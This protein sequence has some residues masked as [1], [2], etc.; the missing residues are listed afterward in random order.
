[1][2]EQVDPSDAVDAA[3]DAQLVDAASYAR[4]GYPHEL[5]TR[6]RADAPVARIEPD[7]YEPFWA[8]TKHADVLDIAKQPL[9][10]S[11]AQGITLRR[12]GTWIPPSELVVMLDPPRH[13]PVR[14]VANP[15]FTP[16]AVT[17]RRTEIERIAVE[18]LDAAAP[19]GSSGDFDFVERIAAPFPLAVIASVLGVPHHDWPRLL[20]WTNEVIGKEDPEYRQPG[21]TPGQTAKRARGEVHAYFK[22]L[23]EQRR[24]EPQA[25]LMTELT[26]GEIDGAPLTDEQL[27]LYCELLVEAG[28]ET[29]RNAITGGLLAFCEH[30]G[31][32]EKL[33]DRPKLLADAVEEILRWVTPISHFTRTATEDS[34]IRG[35]EIQAGEQVALYFASANR[36]EDVFDDPFAFRVDRSPNPHLAFGFGAH[37]C[38]GAQI[39][40]V[41]LE[42]IF[43]LLLA[44]LDS[45]EVSGPVDRLASIVNGSI[46]HLPLRYNMR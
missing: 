43:R 17:A 10:F 13:G 37:F 30:R 28:N 8:I 9:R 6:L 14:R 33:R 4:D 5:W 26:R 35:E 25:D 46:K 20:Q 23:I 21:E 38:M 39:A 40:R 11:S 45:F 19:A 41:E 42:M 31:E 36:D 22:G 1:M 32:W 16:R 3:H 12:A 34:V 18:I 29:T 7:G 27:V 44:R 2:S 24:R 15:G